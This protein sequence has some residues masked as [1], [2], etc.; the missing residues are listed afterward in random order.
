MNDI[1]YYIPTMKEMVHEIS[2]KTMSNKVVS[3]VENFV[4]QSIVSCFFL[5]FVTKMTGN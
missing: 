2:Q 4:I 5:A 1:V 3:H